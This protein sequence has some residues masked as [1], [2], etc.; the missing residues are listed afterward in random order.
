M[1]LWDELE[2][3]QSR[4]PPPNLW[5]TAD[6]QQDV[7]DLSGYLS[8]GVPPSAYVRD[9]SAKDA[10]KQHDDALF[11]KLIVPDT[12]MAYGTT[13]QAEAPY[14]ERRVADAMR[15]W[16]VPGSTWGA[17]LQAAGA[18]AFSSAHPLLKLGA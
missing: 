8:G 17:G 5:P 12:G 10:W 15:D 13:T 1:A 2:R 14:T 3:A 9:R 7:Q 4:N 11:E 16:Y 6:P 18:T